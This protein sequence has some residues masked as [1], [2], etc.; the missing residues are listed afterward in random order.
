LHAVIRKMEEDAPWKQILAG[1][2]CSAEALS[3]QVEIDS[4]GVRKVIA[5]YPMRV[6]PY[7]LGLIG[8]KGDPIYKQCV[9]DIRELTEAAGYEDPLDEEGLSPV[10][11]ITHRYPDRVLFLISSR[12]AVYCRFCN[13]KRKVGK[14]GM[15]TRET[16]L[17]GLEYI[18][19]HREVRD[20]LLSGGDPLLLENQILSKILSEVRSIPHVEVIRIG[21]RTPCTLPQ[22]ITPQLAK[23]LQRFHPLYLQTHFNYPSEITHEAALAC[24]RLA[25]AGIPVSCQTVLLKGVNDDPGVMQ[26]LMRKLL[27]IRVRPYYLFQADL[28]MGTSHFWT[29]LSR[30]LEI[31]DALQGHTSGLGVPHFAVDLPGG[32]GKVRLVPER[33]AGVEGGELLVKN[34]EGRTFRYPL[35]GDTGSLGLSGIKPVRRDE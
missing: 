35:M 31:M 18:R 20:V 32:G 1:S 8:G 2:I 5:R 27:A 28:A 23:L 19:R 25:D 21:T 9:P 24:E 7:Y 30:G 4:A 3:S 26:T 6:N 10:P 16:I 17:A 22:R 29:P 13:R 15:V 33:V 34:H 14:P 11:G 12:C